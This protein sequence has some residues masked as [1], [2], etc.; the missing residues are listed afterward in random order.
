MHNNFYVKFGFRLVM[1]I[2]LVRPEFIKNISCL[3]EFCRAK[4]HHLMTTTK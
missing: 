2:I 3:I 4:G 1:V